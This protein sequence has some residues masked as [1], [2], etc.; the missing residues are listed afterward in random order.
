MIVPTLC[1]GN[2][3]GD[4]PRSAVEVI[5]LA[6]SRAGSFPQGITVPVGASLLAKLLAVSY[7][8]GF[9]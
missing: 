9:G 5:W 7:G 1:V 8:A 3:A 6:S 4:A 2:A